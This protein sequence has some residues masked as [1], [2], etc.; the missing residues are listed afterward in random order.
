MDWMRVNKQKLNSVKMEVLLAAHNL[1]LG[2][3]ITLV[4]DGGEDVIAARG[5]E[6]SNTRLDFKIGHNFI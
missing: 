3:G 6:E 2:R 1:T 5:N 4:L